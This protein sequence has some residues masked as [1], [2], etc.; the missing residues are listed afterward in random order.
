MFH[1]QSHRDVCI[2]NLYDVLV[3]WDFY[4]DPQ[5]VGFA[6]FLATDSY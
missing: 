6:E 1:V 5:V 4:M 3:V 2:C